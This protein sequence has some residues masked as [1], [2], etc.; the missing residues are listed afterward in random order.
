MKYYLLI[1]FLSSLKW[2][3]FFWMKYILKKDF[4]DSI[5]RNKDLTV[6][7]KG[8]RCF[9]IG[10][11]PSINNVN[12]ELLKN[13]IKFTVNSI[14]NNFE[15][16]EKIDPDYHIIIDP[17]YFDDGLPN[18]DVLL[19]D[20]KNIRTNKK[21][22][23]VIT[24][25]EGK[26]VISKYEIDQLNDFYYIYSHGNLHS[27]LIKNISLSRN[28]PVAQNVIQM[29]IYAAISMG[30]R[31]I[32]LLGCEMTSFMPNLHQISKSSDDKR[33]HAYDYTPEIKDQMDTLRQMHDN[34]SVFSDYAKTFQIF[35][36]IRLYAEK[37]NIKI[38]NATNSGVLDV[39]EVVDMNLHLQ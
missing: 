11:G 26:K 27:G 15:L 6:S 29:A 23:K 9:I 24:S 35:K 8:G 31:D 32:Y 7:T 30:F 33:Y 37:H 22:P 5:H 16:F 19:H 20:L 28:M 10:N 3:F 21:S 2:N 14:M 13:E 17:A 4:H 39:F 25:Y 18:Y 12:F 1:C 34:Y 38:Y 36:D